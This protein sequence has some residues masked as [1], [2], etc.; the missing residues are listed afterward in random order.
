M[1]IRK[2]NLI[3]THDRANP[4]QLQNEKAVWSESIPQGLNGKLL[5]DA[6]ALLQPWQCE[7][8]MKKDLGELSGL[9]MF[10]SGGNSAGERHGA[11]DGE[12]KW[13][14]TVIV[15]ACACDVNWIVSTQRL[16]LHLCTYLSAALKQS[17]LNMPSVEPYASADELYTFSIRPVIL[18]KWT[19]GRSSLMST[20][21]LTCHKGNYSM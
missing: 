19:V 16:F 10:M 5:S 7:N 8:V 20:L 12:M 17:E 11:G 15:Y 6:G 4:S 14:T 3:W 1:Q 2:A 13:P 21:K 18:V 9:A